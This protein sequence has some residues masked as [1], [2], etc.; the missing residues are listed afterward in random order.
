LTKQGAPILPKTFAYLAGWGS[1]CT[2]WKDGNILYENFEC[3]FMLTEGV[4]DP[5]TGEVPGFPDKKEIRE[6]MR[7]E[8]WQGDYR[9]NQEIRQR[10]RE[11]ADASRAG[12]QLHIFAHSP[13]RNDENLPPYETAMHFL[14]KNV[15]WWSSPQ[16]P[17]EGPAQRSDE[18]IKRTIQDTLKSN[19]LVQAED[20]NVDVKQGHVT[21]T[22]TAPSAVA[23]NHAFFAAWTP[24]VTSVRNEIKLQS[25]EKLN[26]RDLQQAI[27]QAYGLDPRVTES[28]PTVKVSDGVVTLTGTVAGEQAKRA[29]ED[30][31]KQFD[32]VKQV[33]NRLKID[34][35]LSTGEPEDLDAIVVFDVDPIEPGISKADREIQEN[36]ESELTWSP[37]VDADRVTVAV[38]NRTAYLFGSVEDRSEMDAAVDNAFEGGAERVVN[39][40]TIEQG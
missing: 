7:G 24:G 31:A 25:E 6:L 23:K 34:D 18:D 12:L 40:L 16:A 19:A 15:Q 20:I 27:K 28:R 22:G 35:S 8:K 1:P 38:R 11:S 30:I 5:V 9:Q 3:H 13:Q 21:L 39:G 26:D 17:G 37:Y 33:R 32:G 29:A 36:I 14:W 4:R 10:I 2:V